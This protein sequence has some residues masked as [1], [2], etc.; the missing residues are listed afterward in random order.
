[1][2]NL[3][4]DEQNEV[5]NVVT[6]LESAQTDNLNDFKNNQ[7]LLRHKPVDITELDRLA[8]KNNVLGTGYQTEW[9]VAVMKGNISSLF[10]EILHKT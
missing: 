2:Q 10:S 6:L 3:T 1:M 4:E 5:E 8:V 7:N 9:A